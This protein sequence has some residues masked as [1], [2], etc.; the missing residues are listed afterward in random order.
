[1]GFIKIR[2][3]L[4]ELEVRAEVVKCRQITLRSERCEPNELLVT[5]F[6]NSI[7][8]KMSRDRLLASAFF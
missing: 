7:Q 8:C 3:R 1:M 2:D 4:K 6:D 5:T